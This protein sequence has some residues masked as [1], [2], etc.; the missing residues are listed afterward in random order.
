MCRL[1]FCSFIIY[2]R[3]GLHVVFERL[4]LFRFEGLYGGPNYKRSESI[5]DVLSTLFWN[6]C[7]T[8]MLPI[9]GTVP[10]ILI[11]ESVHKLIFT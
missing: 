3:E 9:P 8:S 10:S 4:K 5:Y 1:M 7:I 2:F 6:R 11:P